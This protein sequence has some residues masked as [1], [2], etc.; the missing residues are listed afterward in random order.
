MTTA[1]AELVPAVDPIVSTERRALAVPIVLGTIP[2]AMRRIQ[3]RDWTVAE[4]ENT[5]R[6]FLEIPD[7]QIT[8]AACK[9][10]SQR[11]GLLWSSA[12]WFMDLARSAAQSHESLT[13]PQ[14]VQLVAMAGRQ[15]EAA[16]ASAH[17]RQP[18]RDARH[19]WSLA[20]LQG[21]RRPCAV[22]RRTRPH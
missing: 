10:V 16:H 19:V 12:T 9:H 7:G 4:N 3:K 6:V 11:L 15:V 22:R 2:P 1:V 5:W 14:I 18:L 20:N 13:E 17:R 8:E 21:L